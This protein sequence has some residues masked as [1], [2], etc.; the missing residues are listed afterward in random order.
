MLE[1]GSFLTWNEVRGGA[2]PGCLGGAWERAHW[3]SCVLGGVFFLV[4][5]HGL[6]TRNDLV[7]PH[8]TLCPSMLTRPRPQSRPLHT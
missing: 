7:R 2:D 1:T 6:S 5:A 8:P 3:V 4:L